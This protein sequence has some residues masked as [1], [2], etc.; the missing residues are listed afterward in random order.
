MN[1]GVIW[2]GENRSCGRKTSPIATLS[3]TDV[4]RV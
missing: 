3:T 4:T 1:M 2:T